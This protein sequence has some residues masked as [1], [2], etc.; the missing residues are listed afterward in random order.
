M[1]SKVDSL[2][3]LFELIRQDK[4]ANG[5]NYS[6]RDRYPIRFVLFDNFKDQYQF[7]LRM[8]GE[9]KVLQD[10]IHNWIDAD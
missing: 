10:S 4:E 7:I 2:D 1:Y 8:I 9:R 3:A 5:P 6:T